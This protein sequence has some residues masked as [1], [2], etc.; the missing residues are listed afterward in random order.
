MMLLCS[1]TPY[2]PR[3]WKT[4]GSHQL[5]MAT[6]PPSEPPQTE[7]SACETAL[8][9]PRWR[10]RNVSAADPATTVTWPNASAKNGE[11]SLSLAVSVCA[12]QD[13]FT[14]ARPNKT[15]TLPWEH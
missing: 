8:C 2:W 3:R 10:S 1:G 13:H 14:M 15:S 7:G 12:I 9:V 6:T 11:E 5:L 4:A